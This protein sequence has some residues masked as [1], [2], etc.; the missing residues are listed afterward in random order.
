MCTRGER[1]G[2]R[3]SSVSRR[4]YRRAA[5]AVTSSVTATSLN[6]GFVQV[7]QPPKKRQK[8]RR[9]NG[10]AG[11]GQWQQ[12]IPICEESVRTAVQARTA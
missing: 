7:M 8:R 5:Y 3:G 1:D 12:E 9:A 4:D 6:S 2:A 11:L 10:K